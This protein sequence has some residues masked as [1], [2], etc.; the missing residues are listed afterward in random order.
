MS[1]TAKIVRRVLS[2]IFLSLLIA[3]G[4][5]GQVDQP[6]DQ[7]RECRRVAGPERERCESDSTLTQALAIEGSEGRTSLS[8]ELRLPLA[9]I[10]ED[11][12]HLQTAAGYLAEAASQSG[13]IDFDALAKS[14][15][16]ISR[17]AYRLKEGLALTNPEKSAKD[18][19]VKVFLVAWQV[20]TALWA[21]SALIFEV[22]PNPVLKG[23][24]LDVTRSAKASSELDKII[25]LSE[26]IQSSCELHMRDRQ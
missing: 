7:P 22:V 21:L 6:D 16:E 3:P 9:Q 19:K 10:R 8:G 25:D 23:R 1:S 24:L 18:R 17:R 11:V 26:R 13:E 20:R 14:T 2:P 12:G 15:S 5:L 4:A